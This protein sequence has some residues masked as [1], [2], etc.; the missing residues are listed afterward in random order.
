MKK[1]A[2]ILLAATSF[3]PL[4][5]DEEAIGVVKELIVTTERNL[6]SQRRLLT[7]LEDFY[8]ARDGFVQDSA[9]AQLGASLVRAAM[10]VHKEM[11]EE[12]LAHLFSTEF[13]E[14]IRF[15]NQMGTRAVQARS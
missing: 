8:K 14:E 9:N 6:E 5:G 4:K 13:L 7:Y 11:E 12:H 2:F 15:F 10:R 1:I 3:F